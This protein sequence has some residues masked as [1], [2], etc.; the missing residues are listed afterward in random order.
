LRK[1]QKVALPRRFEKQSKENQKLP[2]KS[3]RGSVTQLSASAYE[4][5]HSSLTT[6]SCAATF[7]RRNRDSIRF[8]VKSASSPIAVATTPSSIWP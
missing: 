4:R 1:V 2:A 3:T 6:R 7:S 5:F 8:R